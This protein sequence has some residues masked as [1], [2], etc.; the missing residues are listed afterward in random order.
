MLAVPL[1]RDSAA[2]GAIFLWRRESGLF[3]PDQVALVQTFARQ[4]SI[5]VDNVRLFKATKRGPAL[6]QQTATSEIL[7]AISSSPTDVQPVFDIIAQRAGTLCGAEVAIVSRFDGEV[8]EFAAIEG[9]DP[10]AVK[11]L[12]S[13]Y[14]MKPDAQTVT[15]R[16]IR[17]ATVVHISDVFAEKGYEAKDVA[18]AA[19]YRSALGVPIVR[20]R[21]VIGAIFVGRATPGLFADSQVELL[22]TFSEQAVI[23]IENVRLFT[24]LDAR[25]RDLTETLEQQTATSNVLKVISRLG[26]R[27]ATGPRHGRRERG[28][29]VRRRARAH[30]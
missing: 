26:V 8:I 28:T 18:R 24:E 20:D 6:E 3:T 25:N 5:A 11:V 7:R 10:G 29:A 15:A 17:G 14:P 19:R 9:V 21:R 13:H 2:Y 30:A 1:L 22:K 27:P 23:A 4:V 16:V 12:K